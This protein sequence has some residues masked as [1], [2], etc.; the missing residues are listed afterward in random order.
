MGK[1]TSPEPNSRAGE[2]HPAVSQAS[3]TV[4]VQTDQSRGNPHDGGGV[5]S[6]FQLAP[7]CLLYATGVNHENE[8]SFV[9]SLLRKR[10]RCIRSFLGRQEKIRGTKDSVSS[11]HVISLSGT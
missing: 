5:L 1:K 11:V 7:Y 2:K 6:A 9:F 4:D 10:H 3:N 8:R